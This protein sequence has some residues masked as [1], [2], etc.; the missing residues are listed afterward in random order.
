MLSLVVY[1]CYSVKRGMAGSA[2][3]IES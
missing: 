2:V 1:D 3:I